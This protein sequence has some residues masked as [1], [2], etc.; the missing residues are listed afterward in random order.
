MTNT[1]AFMFDD[2]KG[3]LMGNGSGTINYDTGEIN[4]TSKP[5]ASF[6]VSVVHTS[7]LSGKITETTKNTIQEIKVK[8]INPKITGKINLVVRG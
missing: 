3:N 5:N 1:S 6:V 7:A 4:F 2:G 8:S